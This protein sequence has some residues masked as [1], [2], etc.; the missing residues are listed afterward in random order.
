M[1]QS[2]SINES[3]DEFRKA[4]KLGPTANQSKSHYSVFVLNGRVVLDLGRPV[5]TLGFN[6]KEARS[7][8][9]LLAQRAN[10][11]AA[12]ARKK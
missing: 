7:L 3:L 6:V 2:N 1:Q 12:L 9:R 8:S 4:L 5:Q 11:A 10:E